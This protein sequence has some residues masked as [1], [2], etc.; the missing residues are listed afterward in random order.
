MVFNV[1]ENALHTTSVQDEPSENHDPEHS[2]K[3][4]QVVPEGGEF[5]L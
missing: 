4:Y 3:W 1:F 5:A 2:E